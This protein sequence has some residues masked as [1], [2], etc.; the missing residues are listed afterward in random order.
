LNLQA[1]FAE[2][3]NR[4]ARH[5][6]NFFPC[7]DEKGLWKLNTISRKGPG[8]TTASILLLIALK[9][10]VYYHNINKVCCEEM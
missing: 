7:K 2:K 4:K 1:D 9:D 8:E 5:E 3:I 6:R 10:R